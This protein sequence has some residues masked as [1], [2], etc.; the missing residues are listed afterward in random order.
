MEQTI[1]NKTLHT[2]AW[3][4]LLYAMDSGVKKGIYYS[5]VPPPHIIT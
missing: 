4:S 2:K 3:K 5:V 1:H